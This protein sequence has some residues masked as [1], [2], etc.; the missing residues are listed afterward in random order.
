MTIR[1][2]LTALLLSGGLVAQTAPVADFHRHPPQTWALTHASLH[3]D[4]ETTIEDGLLVI[5]DGKIAYA[6]KK[7]NLPADATEIDLTGR[8]IYP[9]FI[10]LYFP[11]QHKDSP[12]ASHLRHW[13]E[14]VHAEDLA[15]DDWSPEA[16]AVQHRREAGFGAGLAVPQEGI[17][18]GTGGVV[19]LDEA[20]TVL[21][22]DLAQVVQFRYGGWS[23]KQYP[24]SLLGCIALIRQ[25]LYD[26]DWYRRAWQIYEK[27]PD[28]NPVPE[29][30]PALDRLATARENNRPFLFPTGDELAALRAIKIAREFHLRLWLRGSGYEYRRLK[31]IA[32]AAPLVIAP[33][34]YPAP[35]DVSDPYRALQY[36]TEQLKHWDQAPDNLQRM[37]AAGLLFS[38]TPEG[39]DSPK[40]FHQNLVRSVERGLAPAEAL[41]ALTTIP[42]RAL[43]LENQLG[44]LRPGALANLTITDGDYFQRQTKVETVWIGGKRYRIEE[45]VPVTLAGRWRLTADAWTGTLSFSG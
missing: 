39:T 21:R 3:I 35:P 34:N 42:A 22:P 33:V 31:E 9:G 18:A 7:T 44:R 20:G 36:S 30:N 23:S 19:L 40:T 11:V 37:H 12:S 10:D 6:G 41:A 24:N 17:F 26:A 27:Y 4:P 5:R 25:T 14:Q 45:P 8:H 28:R 32:A 16:A 13:N 15:V 2:L 43:G 38:I 1:T 29:T